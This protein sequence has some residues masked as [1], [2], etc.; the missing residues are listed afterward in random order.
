MLYEVTYQLHDRHVSNRSA[1]WKHIHKE[2]NTRDD[3][4]IFINRICDN[5]AVKHISL[6]QTE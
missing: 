6:T 5:V 3:A 1:Y 2:F 4:L